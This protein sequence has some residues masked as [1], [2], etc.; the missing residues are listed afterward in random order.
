[1]SPE[2]VR[3]PNGDH[4]KYNNGSLATTHNGRDPRALKLMTTAKTP[5]R[6][7][8]YASEHRKLDS[9]HK[10]KDNTHKHQR[11]T[12]NRMSSLSRISTEV[13]QILNLHTSDPRP[14]GRET[15]TISSAMST[16]FFVRIQ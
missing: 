3:S 11:D 8:M 12:A 2:S 7:A 6:K 16:R 9:C 15:V 10:G 14:K 4:L 5:K 1:M 13:K